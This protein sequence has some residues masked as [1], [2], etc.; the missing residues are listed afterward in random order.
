VLLKIQSSTLP[1]QPN[2][3]EKAA[4]LDGQLRD[5]SQMYENYFLNEMV[6][7]MRSTVHRD[8]GMMKPSFAEKI[9]EGQLD[10]QYVDGWAKKGGIG[11]ADM[12]HQQISE[13]YQAATNQKKGVFSLKGS[14]PIAP[15][16]EPHGIPATDSMQM[17]A[18]PPGPQ[19]KLEYRFEVPNP[20][21]A[22]FEAQAPYAG[23]VVESKTLG[24]GWNLV[25]LDH[26]QGMSSEL[27][28]PGSLPEMGSGIE[29]EAG[30]KLGSIDSSRPVLA[31]KL[32]WT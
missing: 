4:K 15:K 20:S 21:G 29:V 11:L 32:D 10:Q 17:K 1:I 18:I 3:E 2:A 13:R 25:K 14:L 7:A 16:K 24:E 30:Q 23:K 12:I 22:P 27:T 6:K 5:A 8:G 31:W 26:G 9:F 19:S 28:F